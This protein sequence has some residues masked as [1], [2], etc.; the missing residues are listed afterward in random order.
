[1]PPDPRLRKVPAICRYSAIRSSQNRIRRD[2]KKIRAQADNLY[3][4]RS[5][6]RILLLTEGCVKI[7]QLGEN[8]SEIILRLH[9][10]GELLGASAVERTG[11]HGSTAEALL[12]CK[13]IVWNAS[14]FETLSEKF[15]TL[16]RNTMRI[17]TR[18][19]L[20]LEGRLF[21]ISTERVA[22]RLARELV[23]LLVHVGRRVDG[24]IEVHLSREELAQLT[25][26]TL[27]TVSRV[28]SGWEQQAS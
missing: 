22:P 21:E 13:A 9:G 2:P 25:G 19:L 5:G 23:R 27:F 15:P 7:T 10:P 4:R 18:R 6:Q 11:G 24:V 20:E 28:L 17:L 14:T 16:Q 1:M 3:R 26:T 8:G 12:A